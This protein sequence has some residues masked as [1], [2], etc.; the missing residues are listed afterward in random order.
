MTDTTDYKQI[1]FKLQSDIDMLKWEYA[2]RDLRFLKEMKQ[3]AERAF[4]KRDLSAKDMLY[5]M[6]DDWIRELENVK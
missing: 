3:H 2:Q 6:I 4:Y 1:A 5:T